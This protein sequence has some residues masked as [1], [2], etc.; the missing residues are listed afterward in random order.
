MEAHWPGWLR[1]VT[2]INYDV[3][4]SLAI[5]IGGQDGRQIGSPRSLRVGGKDRGKCELNVRARERERER[6]RVKTKA[7]RTTRVET[8]CIRRTSKTQKI[9]ANRK[10]KREGKGE[11]KNTSCSC[12]PNVTKK[13]RDRRSLE[14]DERVPGVP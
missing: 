11:G 4:T 6:A 14:M 9:L 10:R 5:T 2:R 8:R 7:R 12:E 3:I 13:K 1:T